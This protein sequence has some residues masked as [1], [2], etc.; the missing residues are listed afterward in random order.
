MAVVQHNKG[1]VR[2]VLDF[3]ELNTYID[4]YTADSDFCSDRLREWWKQGTNVCHRSKAGLL[5]SAH[6]R[7]AL[8]VSDCYV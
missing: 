5:T 7:V 3:R 8:A 6:S 1:K 4:T 2:P